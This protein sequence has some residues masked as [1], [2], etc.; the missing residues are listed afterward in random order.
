MVPVGGAPLPDDGGDGGSRKAVSEVVPG[1]VGPLWEARV[2]RAGVAG[3]TVLKVARPWRPCGVWS[4]P[5][6]LRGIG[7][8]PVAW[9]VCTPGLA[10]A[11]NVGTR[12]VVAVKVTEHTSPVARIRLA[13]PPGGTKRHR[14]ARFGSGLSGTIVHV[15]SHVAL[16]GG[17]DWPVPVPLTAGPGARS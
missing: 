16:P 5:A 12:S 8:T 3:A 9:L 7:V 4:T 14:V 10:S 2:E 13:S 15:P 11:S 1:M 6:G 17:I